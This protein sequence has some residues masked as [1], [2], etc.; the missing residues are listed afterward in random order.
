MRQRRVSRG[1]FSIPLAEELSM[2]LPTALDPVLPVSLSLLVLLGG[3]LGNDGGG[4]PGPSS[5]P[6]KKI[7]VRLARGPN[8]LT[9]VLGKE[10]KAS[11]PPWETIQGQ[12]GEYARLAADLA[13]HTPPKGSA[14]SWARLTS[15]FAGS[16]SE[17]DKVA[18]AKDKE[19]ALAA[20]GQLT[21]SC[22]ACHR[23]HRKMGPGM[24]GPSEGFPGGSPPGS[25]GGGPPPR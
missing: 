7:M 4:A 8:S 12:A 11:E 23:E 15:E 22:K 20:Y 18:Q 2:A 10:L 3:C 17:L 21:N 19:A 24:G 5:S 14:E 16:A 1:E 9:P 13:K 25:P 6:T